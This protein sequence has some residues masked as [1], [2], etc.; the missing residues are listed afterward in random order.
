MDERSGLLYQTLQTGYLIPFTENPGPWPSVTT[1]S[2]LK[3]I[4]K[5][6]ITI[7]KNKNLKNKGVE[8]KS[9]FKKLKCGDNLI[10]KNLSYYFFTTTVQI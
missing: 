7:D 10:F 5:I 4:I 8:L 2:F 9:G 6:N 1:Q 3:L